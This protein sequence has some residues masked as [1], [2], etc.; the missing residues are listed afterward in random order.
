MHAYAIS[1]PISPTAMKGHQLRADND[2]AAK[3]SRSPIRGLRCRRRVCCVICAAQ[4]ICYS[5][6][7]QLSPSKWRPV[8]RLQTCLMSGQVGKG[9][10]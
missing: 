4:A 5:I 3:L 9:R 2:A 10:P 7:P 1:G 6:E 8:L